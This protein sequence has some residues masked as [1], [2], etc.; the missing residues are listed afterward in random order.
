MGIL[1]ISILLSSIPMLVCEYFFLSRD[2]WFYNSTTRL[3]IDIYHIPVEQYIAIIVMPILCLMVCIQLSD[4]LRILALNQIVVL[5]NA[6]VLIML[7]VTAFRNFENYIASVLYWLCAF[8]LT[9]II[10]M[11]TKWMLAFYISFII[12][13]LPAWIYFRI[14]ISLPIIQYNDTLLSGWNIVDVP[15]ESILYHFLLCMISCCLYFLLI[16]KKTPAK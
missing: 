1:M 12:C 16:R 6:M 5:C 10:M 9:I 14:L 2:V 13:L 15:I 11:K 3:G 7:L 4:K 8:F